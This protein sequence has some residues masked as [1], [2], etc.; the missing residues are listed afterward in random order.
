MLVAWLVSSI[1]TAANNRCLTRTGSTWSIRYVLSPALCIS[2]IPEASKLEWVSG[3]LRCLIVVAPCF[4]TPSHYIVS[5]TPPT[6]L[7]YKSLSSS[8]M[9]FTR[10]HYWV[11]SSIQHR[12]GYSHG[13]TRQ[14]QA[15][16]YHHI[17]SR[18][19]ASDLCKA[20]K[21]QNPQPSTRSECLSRKVSFSLFPNRA[22]KPPR[23]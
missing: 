8:R 23:N 2:S 19:S 3:G 21:I 12:H 17:R 16:N 14:E 18:A 6:D 4:I 7:V 11:K 1:S 13:A 9:G 15:N 10:D 22:S 20:L 5:V